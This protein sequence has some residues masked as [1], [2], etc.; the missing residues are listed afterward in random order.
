MMAIDIFECANK[1]DLKR[2]V[3]FPYW[4]YRNNTYWVPPLKSDELKAL[5]VRYNPAYDFC[6]A[7]WWLAVCEGEV[8]GR[9]GAIVNH[10][11]IKKVGEKIGRFSRFEC[12]NDIRVAQTLLQT[13]ENWLKSKGMTKVEGPLGFSNLDHQGLLVDG[14][15]FIPSIGSQYHFSYYKSHLEKLGYQKAIDWLE[16]RIFV[17]SVP[18]KAKR[19]AEVVEK[20]FGFKVVHFNSKSQMKLYATDIFKLLNEAYKDLFAVVHLSNKMTEYYINRY[21]SLLNPRFVKVVE[22]KNKELIGFIIAIP[23]LSRALQKS[24]GKLFPFGW[25]YLMK[26]LK[27][28][29]EVDL[30]LAA[31]D[32]KKQH[33]GAASLLIH[34]LQVE[35]HAQG[36]EAVETTGVF[37]TNEKA[38]KSWRT[39]DHIQHKRK[40]CLQKELV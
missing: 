4:L 24:K 34:A 8:V 23:S 9:I 19:V 3:E 2:F 30:L 21:M 32:P 38:L 11:H 25:Y 36:V 39:H 22:N 27:N 18:D 33:T 6:E 5:I 7:K 13:A 28:P 40:R 26:A 17:K 35:M 15:D 29:K 12:I 10:A 20:R 16:F 31:V 37:E 14:F 1:V